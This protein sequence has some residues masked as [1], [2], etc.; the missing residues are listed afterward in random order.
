[1]LEAV[2][3]RGR[4]LYV[5]FMNSLSFPFMLSPILAGVIVESSSFQ[6]LFIIST[7]FAILNVVLSLRLSE[8]RDLPPEADVSTVYAP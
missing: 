5:G 4:P 8:P 1:M 7:V 2:P 6:A 3:S